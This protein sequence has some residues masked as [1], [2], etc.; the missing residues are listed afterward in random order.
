MKFKVANIRIYT[1]AA[2]HYSALI[3]K[4]INSMLV[5][6]LEM[7]CCAVMTYYFCMLQEVHQSQEGEME[8][9]STLSEPE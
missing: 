5:R 9:S 1:T 8:S 2:S 4:Y 3:C 6:G 7:A